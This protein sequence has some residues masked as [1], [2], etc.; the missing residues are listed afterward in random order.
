MAMLLLACKFVMERA[1]QKGSSDVISV[2]STGHENNRFSG[3]TL[4][5]AWARP[6]QDPAQVDGTCWQGAIISFINM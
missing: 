3:L 2:S 5:Q 4:I 1:E 6:G